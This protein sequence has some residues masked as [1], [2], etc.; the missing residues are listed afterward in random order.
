MFGGR[1]KSPSSSSSLFS[2]GGTAVSEGGEDDGDDGVAG[3][4]SGASP[5]SDCFGDETG[6]FDGVGDWPCLEF[7]VG[8]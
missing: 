4:C 3:D 1:T 7:G 2:G 5:S 8:A 6:S